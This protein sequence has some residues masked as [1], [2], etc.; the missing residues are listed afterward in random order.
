M[1]GFLI[2]LLPLGRRLALC[3][4]VVVVF[5]DVDCA[6]NCLVKPAGANFMKLAAS[7]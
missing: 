7:S 1:P 4:V 5:V 6:V 3:F 2:L